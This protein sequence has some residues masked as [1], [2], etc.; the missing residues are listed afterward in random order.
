MVGMLLESEL[1]MAGAKVVG[2]ACSVTE[3]LRLIDET[4][5]D[6]GINAAVL[7]LN[8][9][10]EPVWLV[11]DALDELGIPFL[12]ETGYGP[13]CNT[14]GYLAAPVL[15][16]PFDPQMLIGAVKALVSAGGDAIAPDVRFRASHMQPGAPYGAHRPLR[17]FRRGRTGRGQC[18]RRKSQLPSSTSSRAAVLPCWSRTRMTIAP[19][20][21][22]SVVKA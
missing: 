20:S 2:T 8:L 12:F 9:A 19:R 11:A 17:P 18:S 16:K 21:G 15:H 14:G 13:G 4:A 22:Q 10:G 7:D 1:T 3:A 5:G 6:G